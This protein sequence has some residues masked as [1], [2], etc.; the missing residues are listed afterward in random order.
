MHSKN[1]NKGFMVHDNADDIVDTL[2]RKLLSRHQN[3]LQ[4]SMRRS[5]FN[6]DSV[7]ILYYKCHWITLDMVDHILILCI[8]K[9]KATINP[10]NKDEKYFQLNCI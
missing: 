5:D 10:K 7:Q 8:K 9:K 6:F 3:S 4:T 2:F 1:K